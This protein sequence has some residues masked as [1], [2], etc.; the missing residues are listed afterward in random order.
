MKS[1]LSVSRT[2]LMALVA[3]MALILLGSPASAQGVSR[4]KVLD[5]NGDPVI[6]AP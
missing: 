4:G 2:A 3:S 1:I 5:T 6:G